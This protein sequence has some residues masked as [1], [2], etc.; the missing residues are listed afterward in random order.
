MSNVVTLH[1]LCDGPLL[2]D[3]SR[4]E[5]IHKVAEMAGDLLANASYADRGDAIMT[6]L[7]L[8]YAP[9]E[10]YA[11]VTRACQVATEHVVAMEMSTP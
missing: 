6:L 10:V 2:A 1:R 7:A 9:F 3:V 11:L 5:R 8:G 4:Q